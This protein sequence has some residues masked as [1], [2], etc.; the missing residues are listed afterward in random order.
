MVKDNQKKA[1]VLSII[2][3]VTLIAVVVGATYAYFTA[4]GGGTGNINVNANT[5]TTDNLS[6]QVGEAISLTASEEDFGQGADNKSGETFARATLTA[7]N[8]TNNATRNYYVYLDIASNDFE[9]TTDDNQ[10]EIILKVTDPEGIE[11]TSIPGLTRKTSGSGENEITGFDITTS[12]GLI[13][14]ADNYE[15]VSTGTETQDWNIEVIFVNLDSDQ[16]ANTNKTFNANLIIREN[17]P[18]GITNVNISNI[19]SNSISLTVDAESENEIVNYYYAKNDEE[20][21]SSASNTYTF[22]GLD[23]ATKYTLKVYVVDSKGYQSA[24]YNTDAT[25]VEPTIAEVCNDGANLTNCIKEF[26]NIAGDGVEGIY[27]HDGV[28]DYTNAS[29]EAGDNSYRYA[30]VNPNNY[31]CFGSDAAAC[32]EDNLYRIIGVFGEQIKLIK[33]DFANSDLLGTNGS[34]YPY[35]TYNANEFSNY[36]GSKTT[37]DKFYWNYINASTST[38]NWSASELNTINLNQ[39][40][41]GHFSA[42]WQSKISSISWKVGGNT[43]ANITNATVKNVYQNE[44]V[45]P[46]TSTV[47]SAKIGLM[48]VSDYGYGASPDNWN[49]QLSSYNNSL[50]RENNWLYSGITEWTITPWT[51]VTNASVRINDEG[52]VGDIFYSNTDLCGVRPV[53]YLESNVELSGNHTGTQSDP[54]RITL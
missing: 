7:N 2:G 50:T 11:V 27:Y 9:Y 43:R 20:Y 49:R 8:A 1:L 33:A 17:A 13:T 24:V 10:A 26:N 51:D 53:F 40:F 14:I 23:A 30:G 46:A 44:I 22:T 15:I 38:I 39:N 16:N 45:S 21:V 31:V 35:G 36:E 18:I 3:I 19:T 6:F 42:Q 29:L 34:Y 52:K 28:G 54:Y 12:Q 47:V 41:L 4:Q 48:Y 37:I 5:A 32:P 25:T